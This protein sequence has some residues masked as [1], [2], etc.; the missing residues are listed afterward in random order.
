M[1]HVKYIQIVVNSDVYRIT[2]Q[3][4]SS[5]IETNLGTITCYY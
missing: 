4:I 1:N 5:D 2:A 3:I